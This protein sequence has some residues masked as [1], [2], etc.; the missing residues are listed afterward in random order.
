MCGIAGFM[1]LD[2]PG[3]IEKMT[4]K[5]VHRGPDDVG[6][7]VEQDIALGSSPIKHY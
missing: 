5:L 7:F 4:D 6:H 3:L 2:E 1:G